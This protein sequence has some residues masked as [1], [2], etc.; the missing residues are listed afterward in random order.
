[1]LNNLYLITTL[2]LRI[3]SFFAFLALNPHTV[4]I[5]YSHLGH[6]EKQYIVKLTIMFTCITLS[7]ILFSDA[8]IFYAYDILQ[9]ERHIDNLFP[10][11]GR[12]DLI[13]SD[14]IKWFS[15]ISNRI[16]YIITFFD[17]NTKESEVDFFK[18]N[19]KYFINFN[20]I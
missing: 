17:D 9:F 14:I 5:R 18:G 12:L 2:S 8:C 13:H 19:L 4:Y 10:G 1:M 7:K 6:L 3:L 20:A 11:Y 15:S 16:W